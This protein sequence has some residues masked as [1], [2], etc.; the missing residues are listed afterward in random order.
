MRADVQSPADHQKSEIK[1]RRPFFVTLIT[2]V[3]LI[4]ASTHLV[5]FVEALSEWDFLSSLPRVS[6]AYLAASGLL[7]TLVG[8][9]LIWGLWR[10]HVQ[11]PKA[12]R[13]LAPAYTSYYWLDRILVK[14]ALGS[15]A[16]WPF[17]LGMTIILLILIYWILST[18]RSRSFFGEIDD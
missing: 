14:S 11:A 3:V 1:T 4:I 8:L 16:N 9:P 18:A 13:I 10:G 5:R 7:W 12:I 15:P 17:A 2:V 6:P